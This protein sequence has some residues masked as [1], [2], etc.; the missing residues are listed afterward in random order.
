M[1]IF[2]ASLC[3]VRLGS[4]SYCK[5]VDYNFVY[6]LYSAAVKPLVMDNTDDLKLRLFPTIISRGKMLSNQK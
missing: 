4:S 3:D 6:K 2:D 1:P 5:S